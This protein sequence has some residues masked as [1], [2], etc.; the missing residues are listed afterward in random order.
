MVLLPETPYVIVLDAVY[1]VKHEGMGFTDCARDVLFQMLAFF[2]AEKT[3]K[4]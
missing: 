2:R 3:V 1:F 4:S